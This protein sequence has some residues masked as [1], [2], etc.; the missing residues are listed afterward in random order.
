MIAVVCTILFLIIL[1]ILLVIVIKKVRHKKRA[2]SYSINIP[3]ALS[4]PSA[5]QGAEAPP[6]NAGEEFESRYT[7]VG[8]TSA[9]PTTGM[10]NPV[11]ETSLICGQQV[12][13]LLLQFSSAEDSDDDLKKGN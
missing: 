2:R 8:G 5:H 7:A 6:P 13:P 9:K 3:L 11:Y 10:C 12:E 4:S 1:I